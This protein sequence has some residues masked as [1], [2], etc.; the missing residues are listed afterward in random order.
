MHALSKAIIVCTLVFAIGSLS[1]TVFAFHRPFTLDLE[2][3][4]YPL[5]PRPLC[6]S[7]DPLCE[8]T[9]PPTPFPRGPFD[10]PRWD[11]FCEFTD[12]PP[13]PFPGCPRWD[14]LCDPPYPGPFP[15]PGPLPNCGINPHAP[16]CNIP[17]FDPENNY[18][19]DDIS[20]AL[21][22][23][24]AANVTITI[25]DNQTQDVE[26]LRGNPNV[27]E[28]MLFNHTRVPQLTD[29]ER[30]QILN[31]IDEIVHSTI[32]RQLPGTFNLKYE[33]QY[34]PTTD[35]QGNTTYR[36]TVIVEVDLRIPS[37]MARPYT[38]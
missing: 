10:C 24:S 19:I 20:K 23:T 2:R 8:V 29:I 13:R 36:G 7:W 6:P 38:M 27:V 34:G 1:Q 26:V 25:V 33:T 22:I 11:P 16:P 18:C 31:Q 32:S 3:G 30:T 4:Y 17:C 35:S 21:A 14:P 12:P 37:G 15:L 28:S 9:D 5:P